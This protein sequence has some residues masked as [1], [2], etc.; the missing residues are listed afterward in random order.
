ML[1]SVLRSPSFHCSTFFCQSRINDPFVSHQIRHA[2]YQEAAMKVWKTISDSTPVAYLQEGLVTVHDTSGLPWWATIVLTTVVL[3]TA[4]TLPLS[5]YQF[6]IMGRLEKIS[7]EM[8]DIMEELKR[9]TA[10][11]MK[12]FNWTERQA[13][14]IFSI[15]AK[16]QWN[17]LVVRENCHPVKT[18][19]TVWVQ[20]PL[21]VINSVAIR[22][23]V[24]MLPDPSSIEAQVVFSD[25]MVGGFGW[26]PNL[27]EVD[28]S[29]IL[30]ITLGIVNLSV[31]QVQAVLR[32]GQAG[33]MEKILTNFF[34]VLTLLMVPIAAV[35]PSCLSL[36]W[37]TSSTCGLIQSLAM[38]SPKVRT[39]LGI[40]HLQH[41]PKEKPYKYLLEKFRS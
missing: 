8:P 6:K 4:V 13:K 9:E 28:S 3:R 1:R 20:I 7:K 26:I 15:S 40:P 23:L 35:V 5:V 27:T 31:I 22:N 19:L 38:L 39:I 14:A 29:F 25:L 41:W 37:L 24:N 30:P 34:R 16:K 32:K 10:I 11:A 21:W 36:Y 17:K 12:K 18:A 33:R 2:S